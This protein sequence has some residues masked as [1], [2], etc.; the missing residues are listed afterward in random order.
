MSALHYNFVLSKNVY[1]IN[2]N[3]MSKHGYSWVKSIKDV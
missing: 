2:P 1:L 3:L